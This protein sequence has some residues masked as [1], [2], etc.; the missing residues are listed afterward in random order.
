MLTPRSAAKW[1]GDGERYHA[2]VE[3]LSDAFTPSAVAKVRFSDYPTET[4]TMKVNQL[5]YLPARGLRDLSNRVA[6]A[7]APPPP[8]STTLPPPPAAPTPAA[9][10]P[11][12]PAAPTLRPPP[13]VAAAGSMPPPP[14]A[15]LPP[16]PQGGLPPPPSSATP[17]LPPPPAGN[18]LSPPP[19]TAPGLPPP[20]PG[21]P[22]PPPALP[23][24]P[25]VVAGRH[26]II[27][28][29]STDGAEGDTFE[30]PVY[31]KARHTKAILT[32]ALRAFFMFKTLAPDSLSAVVDAMSPFECAGG[33]EVV[34]Q[35]SEGNLFFAVETGML[36]VVIDGVGVVATRKT[37]EVF[38]EKALLYNAL[39]SATVVSTCA[40][41]LWALD[42]PSFRHVMALSQRKGRAAVIDGLRRVP[43]LAK[44]TP[45]QLEACAEASQ[46]A[47][48]HAGDRIITKGTEGSSFY[49]LL[50]GNVRCTGITSA[51]QPVPDVHLE[52]GAYFGERALLKSLPRAA[53]VIASS[54]VT[55]CVLEADAFAAHLGP[56]RD[57]LNANLGRRVLAA[58]PSLA[59]LEPDARER[60]LAHATT[61][62]H[63]AGTQLVRGGAALESIVVIAQGSAKATPPHPTVP[64]RLIEGDAI[65]AAHPLA[66][67]AGPYI[68]P[69][70]VTAATE[71][72]VVRLSRA[73]ALAAIAGL[74]G[75]PPPALPGPPAASLGLPAAGLGGA[76]GAGGPP[77]APSLAQEDGPDPV[78]A[79]RE[80]HMSPAPLKLMKEKALLG[81]GAFGRVTLVKHKETGRI[82]ALKRLSKQHVVDSRQTKAVVR[83]R[84]LMARMNSPFITRLH[85]TAQDR[86]A[87]YFLMD[88]TLGGELFTRVSGLPGRKL[89]RRDTRFYAGCVLLALRHMH[90]QGIV[91]RDLKPENL[92]I[93]N[94]GYLQVIDFGLSKDIGPGGRTFTLCGTPEYMAPEIV[95]NTGHGNGADY[96]AVGIL[97]FDLLVG[98]TPFA[99]PK[100]GGDSMAVCRLVCEKKPLFPDK[101]RGH[102]RDL[103]EK[104][105]CKDP[106]DRLGCQRRGIKDILDHPYFSAEDECEWEWEE[107]SRRAATPPWVPR[108]V[109]DHDTSQFPKLS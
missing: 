35:G 109:N 79:Q 64:A 96:W 84:S 49:M 46:L 53:D 71:V 88:A 24:P 63:P 107:L 95:L 25:P 4:E 7:A 87:L 48:F 91:Y 44:L 21:L 39:R 77:A 36:D 5:A 6:G 81:C 98:K 45:Q 66:A 43:L 101:L 15:A 37:G 18:G 33:T 73:A 41:K 68:C 38:G 57:V 59:A 93:D 31:P 8:P 20:P 51:G 55:C 83:E 28:A 54:E 10:L 23:P 70:T 29:E 12:P 13:A 3:E 19:S 47:T 78:V 52:A 61:T 58:L 67:D 92:M 104:L 62:R 74:P 9:A 80:R 103:I 27:I 60:A 26:E 34:V 89:P 14:A 17:G 65:G 16:P 97:L 56:L 30:L 86:D 76:G 99:D 50:S 69:S 90:S 72:S 40:C 106:R 102:A 85:G 75:P 108:L 11:P 2:V 100:G 1:S 94:K 22:P 42:R 105:L 82:Y 32:R